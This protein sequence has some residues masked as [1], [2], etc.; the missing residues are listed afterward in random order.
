MKYI[1]VL[2][3]DLQEI[4]Y[5]ADKQTA[6]NASFDNGRVSIIV[7]KNVTPQSGTI[8]T[9]TFET[10]TYSWVNTDVAYVEITS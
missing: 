10:K 6:L 5:E 1:K 9:E 2:F 4:E 7:T 3:V 8:I